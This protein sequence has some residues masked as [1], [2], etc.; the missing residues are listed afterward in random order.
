M[1]KQKDEEFVKITGVALGS[2]QS[3]FFNL[4]FQLPVIIHYLNQSVGLINDVRAERDE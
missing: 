4:L 3:S 2:Q 1:G